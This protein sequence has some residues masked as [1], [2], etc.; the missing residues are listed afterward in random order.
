MQKIWDDANNQDGIRPVS[1]TVALLAN[2]E[3]VNQVEL[4]DGNNWTASIPDLPVYAAGTPI[5]YAW[6]EGE[7]EGYTAS[8]VTAGN[9]TII[10]NTHE[11]ARTVATIVKIWD[12][13]DNRDGVRPESLTARLS[14]GATV[15]LNA[16]NNWTATVEN[17]PKFAAGKE[18][19]YTWTENE[20][21]GYVQASLVTEGT[22]TTIT[23]HHDIA[24]QNLTVV[25]V[26]ED[27]GNRDGLRPA[28]LAVTLNGNQRVVLNEANGW[29]ATIKDQPIYANGGREII[30]RW[31]EEDVDGYQL[32]RATAGT[33]TTLTNTHAPE[34][35]D[36][37]VSK[38]WIDEN[39][40]AR[41]GSLNM[42]LRGS[43]GEV[44]MAVLSATNNWTAT[45][46]GL[47][48]YAEGTEVRY[49]WTEPEIP[50]YIQTDVTTTG[51]STVFTNTR[52]QTPVQPADYTLTINYRYPDGRPAAPTYTETYHEGDPYDIASPQIDGYRA[53][54]L[55]VTGTM[56]GRDLVYTVIYL[57]TD[58]VTVFEELETP[59]GLGKVN[60]N[61]GDCLE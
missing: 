33:V 31:A 39:E 14:S 54:L 13:D 11:T 26:W 45:V 29:R 19:A 32:Q 16:G 5:A 6:D 28:N 3:A 48:R 49:T 37:T 52:R 57:P 42:V 60:L 47:M 36:L 61:V 17:L 53:S 41:P 1:L 24:V 35:I 15:E 56:P 18:I 55:R 58:D 40:T 38:V 2:G 8:F 34:T 50:G 23:N 25:K 20:T 51:N 44:R 7:V 4:N 10:T 27:D 12:D 21:E 59:R 43:N 30:Y 46:T 9:A 22:V